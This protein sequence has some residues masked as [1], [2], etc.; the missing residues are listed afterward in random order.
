MLFALLNSTFYEQKKRGTTR[1]SD[2]C[3][4]IIFSRIR[5]IKETK[6]E[7]MNVVE[8]EKKEAKKYIDWKIEATF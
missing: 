5:R 6:K 1:R 4:V 8:E 3:N 7:E 2:R